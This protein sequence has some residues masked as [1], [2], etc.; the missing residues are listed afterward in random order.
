MA[1]WD[2]AEGTFKEKAGQ[3]TG[4]EDREADGATQGAWGDVKE[5]VGDTVDDVK[6]KADDTFDEARDRAK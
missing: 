1:D 2:Q 3:V 6:D 5:T 4:D